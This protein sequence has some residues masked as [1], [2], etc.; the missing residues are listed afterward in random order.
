MFCA[1]ADLHKIFYTPLVTTDFSKFHHF[2]HNLLL[3]SSRFIPKN[4]HFKRTK[5]SK[6]DFQSP[7]KPNKTIINTYIIHLVVISVPVLKMQYKTVK[8]FTQNYHKIPAI[9]L[10]I[11]FDADHGHQK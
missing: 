8:I 9:K 6:K 1:I 2:T 10:A 7:I 5:L 3:F 4:I 11:E